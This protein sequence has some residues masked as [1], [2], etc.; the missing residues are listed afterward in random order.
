MGRKPPATHAEMLLALVG[1]LS[2][3]LNEDLLSTKFSVWSVAEFVRLHC[4]SRRLD[5]KQLLFC[6]HNNPML[7]RVSHDLAVQKSKDCENMLQVE[8]SKIKLLFYYSFP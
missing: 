3:A 5:S 7:L 8:H 6:I 1:C 2:A 4:L